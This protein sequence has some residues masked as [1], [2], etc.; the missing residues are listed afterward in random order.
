[1][2]IRVVIAALLGL[3]ALA[4][5]QE[6]QAQPR[7]VPPAGPVLPRQLDYFRRDFGLTD[8]YNAFVQPRRQLDYQMQTLA[9]QQQNNFNT[10]Q[11]ELDRLNQIRQSSAAP[12]GVGAGYMNYSHFY[13]IQ[14]GGSRARTR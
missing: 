10:T 5:F 14:P 8:P 1:M 13:R 9:Q 7:Y 2:N 3:S 12:T 4:C 6:A 11:R